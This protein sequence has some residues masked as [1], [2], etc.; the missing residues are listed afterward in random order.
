MTDKEMV[1]AYF[2]NMEKKLL[3]D[4][5]RSYRRERIATRI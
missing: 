1:E 4:I 5:E 2:L 3:A